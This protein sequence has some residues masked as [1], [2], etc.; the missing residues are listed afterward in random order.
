MSERERWIVYPLLFLALGAALRDKF[1]RQVMTDRLHAAQ[2]SCEHLEIIDPDKQGRVV[3]RLTSAD[4]QPGVESSR[5]GV[6]ALLDSQGKEFCGVTNDQLFVRSVVS[7]EVAIVDPQNKQQPLAMLKPA[8]VQNAA[9]KS[10]RRI[11]SLVLTDDKGETHFGL[12]NDQLK[13]RQIV[14]EGV[15]VIDP[16]NPNRT[17][18]GL[19]SLAVKP[20]KPGGKPRR[21]GVLA[22]NNEKFGTL[23]GNPPPDALPVKKQPATSKPETE[24]GA[25]SPAEPPS[26][27]A[28]DAGKPEES[29]TPAGDSDE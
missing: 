15:A 8:L 26:E 13:M 1:T 2:I 10:I 4:P 11:G 25:T 24:L 7:Q 14:C 6:L 3:A 5:V 9:D 12:A 23:T 20:R 21:F 27:T 18:A 29:A 22:L 28:D 19:G 16:A 17:L